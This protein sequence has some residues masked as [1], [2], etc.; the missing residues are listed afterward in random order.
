MIATPLS[1]CTT[2]SST[3]LSKRISITTHADAVQKLFQHIALHQSSFIAPKGLKDPKEIVSY[4]QERFKESFL[5]HAKELL[6]KLHV[7]SALYKNI[8]DQKIITSGTPRLAMI[9][10]LP[11]QEI[12]FSFDISSPIQSNLDEWKYLI[13]KFP[14]RKYY[15]DLD[16]Q[17]EVFIKQETENEDAY[18]KSCSNKITVNDW[19]CFDLWIANDQ[20]KPL[21]PDLRGNFWLKIGSGEIYLPFQELF[22]GKSK[23]E[24]FFTNSL[25]LQEYFSEH[26]DTKYCF[27][28][29][30]VDV[31]PQSYFSIAQL[32]EYF[33]IKT[34]K[35][36]HQKLIEVFSYRNDLSLRRA[37]VEDL[38][39][40][41]LRKQYLNAPKSQILRHQQYLLDEL[42]ENA[43]YP[44]YKIQKDFQGYIEQLAEKQIKEML[45]ID[46]IGYQ[47]NITCSHQD[48]VM[49]LNLTTRART[50]E[51][52]YFQ[53]PI[54]KANS[55]EYPIATE[56]LNQTCL[57]EKT[58]NQII[59]HLENY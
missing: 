31:L 39:A 12:K 54:L 35:K 28:V 6:F 30:I 40:M 24:E 32:Q 26:M 4:I 1:H 3:N 23:G 7:H 55:F 21:L 48:I 49:Y 27:G 53:H 29:K 8:H 13:F 15:K 16:K 5:E 19:V 57:R 56:E 34:K 22:L 58:L 10:F 47:E 59:H 18:L 2:E 38:L 52:I 36:T 42:Q 45:L 20:N 9:D 41:I 43:D 46:Q 37:I 33:K 17:A 44:V 11:S 25:C 14:Q 50:K 51:F